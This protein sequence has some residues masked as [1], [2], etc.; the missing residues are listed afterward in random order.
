MFRVLIVVVVSL[1][2]HL[3][4]LSGLYAFSGS[5]MLYVNY[6]MINLKKCHEYCQK[7]IQATLVDKLDLKMS[8]NVQTAC[9]FN[10]LLI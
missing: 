1:H 3:L 8:K 7:E 10:L 2:I 6:I 5:S 4:K 9:I